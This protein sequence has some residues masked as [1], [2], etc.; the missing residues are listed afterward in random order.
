MATKQNEVGT[1][2]EEYV[3]DWFKARGF[4]AALFPKSQ[5]G[6]PCDIVAAKG[7]DGKDLV[8][9]VDAKHMESRDKSFAFTRVESNQRTAFRLLQLRGVKNIGFAIQSEIDPSR[10]LFLSFDKYIEM[11]GMGLKS[12]ELATLEDME[13]VICK[14]S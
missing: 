14:L 9:F 5:N 11:E 13:E 4:W 12:V 3:R 6:Q 8:L 10:L 7:V 2:T 1:K